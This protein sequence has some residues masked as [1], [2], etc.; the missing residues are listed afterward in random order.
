LKDQH[1]KEGGVSKLV[2]ETLFRNE[3]CHLI[4]K[5]KLQ[6]RKI[7]QKLLKKFGSPF[8]T[9]IMP[10][11]H[12]KMIM[13]LEKE[14]RKKM[15]KKEKDRILVLMGEKPTEQAP[16]EEGDSDDS[17]SSD[18][19]EATVLKKTKADQDSEESESEDETVGQRGYDTL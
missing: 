19:E 8:V 9:K 7:V 5:H 14:K 6:I 3:F 10:V 11:H 2:I 18:E 16:K 4:G 1:L 12:R 17:E 13:Y 15:N